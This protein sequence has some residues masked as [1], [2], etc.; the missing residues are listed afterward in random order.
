M[1]LDALSKGLS[2]LWNVIAPLISDT[3]QN[4]SNGRLDRISLNQALEFIDRS[5]HIFRIQVSQGSE[6]FGLMVLRI[7]AQ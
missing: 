7:V 4:V 5:L 1:S 6:E 3:Q 2:R